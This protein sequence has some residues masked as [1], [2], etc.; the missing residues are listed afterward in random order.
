MEAMF[1]LTYKKA[2][3]IVGTYL[4]SHPDAV[5]LV[6]VY[7]LQQDLGVHNVYLLLPQIR[8]EYGYRNEELDISLTIH[9]ESA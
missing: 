7:M 5:A 8:N 3:K 2:G 9:F 4:H 6:A 1:K